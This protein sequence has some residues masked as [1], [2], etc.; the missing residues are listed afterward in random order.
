MGNS[1]PPSLDRDKQ[2][3]YDKFRQELIAHKRLCSKTQ[4]RFP[5]ILTIKGDDLHVMGNDGTTILFP[6]IHT[7]E[8]YW[9]MIRCISVL[10][11]SLKSIEPKENLFIR[12]RHIRETMKIRMTYDA[13]DAIL[14]P[15][16]D[17]NLYVDNMKTIMSD[18]GIFYQYDCTFTISPN[19]YVQLYSKYYKIETYLKLESTNIDDYE[20]A[21]CIRRKLIG[22]G[23]H[24]CP[25]HARRLRLN[26]FLINRNYHNYEFD[27]SFGRVSITST[28]MR[29]SYKLNGV[30]IHFLELA[31]MNE[32]IKHYIR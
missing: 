30:E 29:L 10:R 28:S 5:F 32:I 15:M 14:E 27:T 2:E 17:H 31:L 1:Q 18:P 20:L 7:E 9:S 13:Y 19:G 24:L 3:I 8:L 22:A 4:F 12:R 25:E 11:E 23:S 6:P 21:N 16:I 26:S